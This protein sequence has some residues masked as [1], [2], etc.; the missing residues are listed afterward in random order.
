M[1]SSIKVILISLMVFL[2][3]IH[4]NQKNEEG[5]LEMEFNTEKN[6]GEWVKSWNTYD[7][8]EVDRLFLQ[9][10]KL[11]YFSS[12]KQGV[13]TGIEAVRKHHK[14]F[15]FVDG[16]KDQPNKLWVED[17]HT[18]TFRTTAVV[19]GIWFFQRPD[20]SKQRG[21]VTIVYVNVKDEFRIAHMNFSN[22]LDSKESR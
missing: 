2:L 10:P 19:T 17:L 15:G 18:S 7:L 12:E 4:C 20:G 21:P 14:G 3:S 16:G 13:I 22:Y 8:N 6:V 1:K 11:T 5:N 9:D